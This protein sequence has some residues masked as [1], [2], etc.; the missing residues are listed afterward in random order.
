MSDF[1]LHDLAAIIAER[2]GANADASY[3]KSLLDG[4]PARAAKK[5][6]EEA[7]EAVIAA[8]EGNRDALVHESA[9]LLY[10]LLVVLQSRGIS[11]SEVLAELE[12]RTRQSGHEEKASRKG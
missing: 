10:H 11:L 8:V 9:D 3:T 2:A 7:V 1:S 12:R 4:G 6:G 5:M